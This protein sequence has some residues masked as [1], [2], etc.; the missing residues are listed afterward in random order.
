[1]FGSR[2]NVFLEEV[3]NLN[4]AV[5]GRLRLRV[6]AKEDHWNQSDRWHLLGTT[7]ALPRV[8]ANRSRSN[9]WCSMPLRRPDTGWY[10]VTVALEERVVD[11]AGIARWAIRDLRE[12]DDRVLITSS[13]FPF[14]PWE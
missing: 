11:A 12:S 5:T 3:D 7:T 6:W 14:F 9:L 4:D 1:M 10:Y 2:L 8:R 13:L